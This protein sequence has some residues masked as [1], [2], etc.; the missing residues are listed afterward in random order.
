[1]RSQSAESSMDKNILRLIEA[2]EK[3]TV[4]KRDI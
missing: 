3:K 4:K 2:S 1:M